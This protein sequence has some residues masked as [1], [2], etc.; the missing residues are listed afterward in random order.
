MYAY[1]FEVVEV[2]IVVFAWPV[3][4][5]VVGGLVTHDLGADF[6]LLCTW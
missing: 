4:G 2:P 3:S 6:E 1:L 5:Q